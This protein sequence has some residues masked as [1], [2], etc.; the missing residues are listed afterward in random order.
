MHT[1]SQ[2][3]AIQIDQ[4]AHDYK[5]QPALKILKQKAE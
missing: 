2:T 4:I 1:R 3:K 5:I